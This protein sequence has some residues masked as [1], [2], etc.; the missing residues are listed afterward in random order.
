ML[1]VHRGAGGAELRGLGIVALARFRPRQRSGLLWLLAPEPTAFG[2]VAWR[3]TTEMAIIGRYGIIPAPAGGRSNPARSRRAVQTPDVRAENEVA[4]V[5][6]V[7]HDRM[8]V[9]VG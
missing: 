8:T 7:V 5:A 1:G 9:D 6:A 4:H 2:A 3:P